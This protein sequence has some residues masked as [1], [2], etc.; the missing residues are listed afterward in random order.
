MSS[1]TD[2]KKNEGKNKVEEK[3]SLSQNVKRLGFMARK[4]RQKE[5]KRKENAILKEIE[6]SKWTIPQNKNKYINKTSDN[7]KNEAESYNKNKIVQDYDF[8]NPKLKHQSIYGRRSFG[9]FN[10]AIEV[11]RFF[12]LF[13]KK[14]H[15]KFFDSS[16]KMKKEGKDIVKKGLKGLK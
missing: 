12:T 2:N 5:E 14:I 4:E 3:K 11:Y 7:Q 16:G 10:K 9:G 8:K 1:I 15:D 6:D 13:L